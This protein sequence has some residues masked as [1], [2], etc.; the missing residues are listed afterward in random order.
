MAKIINGKEVAQQVKDQL[1]EKVFNFEKEN[2]RK[3]T[4]AVILVGNNP[5]SQV[6]VKNKIIATEYVGMRSLSFYLPEDATQEQVSETILNL[7]ND[8]T[9]DGILVQLP[10]PKHLNE[11]KLLSLIPADKDVDGFLA[12]NVGNLVLGNETTVACTPFG[13]LKMLKSENIPL[14]GKNA[15]VIGRSNIVGKPMALLLLQENCTVTICHSKTVNLK[16]I[17]LQADVLIAAIGKPKFVTAD[18]VKKDAVV[19]DVGINRTENGLVGDVDFE[20]VSKVASY[21][22]PVPGGVGPMTIA[23]LLENTYLSAVRK[24]QNG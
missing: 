20:N 16:E 24:K 13:V 5:A 21:I 4:L 6:Y 10:L 12:E 23:M 1:K 8:D 3:I 11:D 17:C 18:M 7:A 22:S 19:I 14:S 15:V 9:V 2:G